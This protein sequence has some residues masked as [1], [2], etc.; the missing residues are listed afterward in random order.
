MTTSFFGILKRWRALTAAVAGGVFLGVPAEAGDNPAM[1]VRNNHFNGAV[2]VADDCCLSDIQAAQDLAEWIGRVFNT[3]VEILSENAVPADNPAGIYLGNTRA[4]K[5][6]VPPESA[7]DAYTIAASGERV[8]IKANRPAAIWGACAAFLKNNLRVHFLMPGENGAEWDS[9]SHFSLQDFRTDIVPAWTWRSAYTLGLWGKHLGFGTLPPFSHNLYKTFN[10]KTL[11]ANPDLRSIAAGTP[12]AMRDSGFSPQPNL[13]AAAA[14]PVTLE[15]AIKFFAENPDAYSFSL[16]INDCTAWDESPEA[17][18]LYGSPV[19]FFNRYVNRSDYYYGYVN[20]V[21]RAL[22]NRVFGCLAY[23]ETQNVPAFPL[24]PNVMPVLCTDRAQWFHESYR[25]RD[26]DLFE[27]WGKSGVK[28]W[29]LWEYY[30]GAPYPFPREFYHAQVEAVKKAHAAGA[31]LMMVEGADPTGIDCLKAWLLA[32]TLENPKNADADAL[33]SLYCRRAFGPAADPMKRFFLECEKIWSRQKTGERWLAGYKIESAEEIFTPEDWENLEKLIDEADGLFPQNPTEGKALRERRRFECVADDFLRMHD[34]SKSY[35]ARKALLD[36]PAETLEEIAETLRSPAWNFEIIAP[37]PADLEISDP[38]PTK[39]LEI[40]ERIKSFPRTP[41]RIAAEKQ[42]LE[43]L[44]KSSCGNSLKLLL[45]NFP[46]RPEFFENFE[47]LPGQFNEEDTP[48][49]ALKPFPQGDWR[50]GKTIAFPQNWEHILYP[51]ETLFAAGT[52][53]KDEIF[54]GDFS[55]KFTGTIECA[56]FKKTV[57]AKPGEL[58]AF[59]FFAKSQIPVA[60]DCRIA[61]IWK[62][63]NNRPL[64]SCLCAVPPGTRDWRRYVAAGTAPE[65][66]DRATL[67]ISAAGFCGNDF[68]IIDNIELRRGK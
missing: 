44:E 45:K 32:E 66:T 29:G 9:L 51:G 40:V 50:E 67:C 60:G 4:G 8:F 13:L 41:E 43:I 46:R 42:L 34:F 63:K 10:T 38:R 3:S 11:A 35:Y 52:E 49:T 28:I 12:T 17:E 18:A 19:T 31:R 54:E 64:G 48:I 7:G 30:E 2:Y 14:V 56:G 62:D 68:A 61:I 1:L 5:T 16:G 39:F 22:P 53:N 58:L 23:N 59:S 25:S 6:I 55:Y 15:A 57:P 27:R 20:K 37:K 21:A 24:E 33:I 36:A 26:L 47:R 65:G